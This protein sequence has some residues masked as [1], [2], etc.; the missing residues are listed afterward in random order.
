MQ[1]NENIL[2]VQVYIQGDLASL[3]EERKSASISAFAMVIGVSPDAIEVYRVY[4]G[5]VVFDLGV[6]AAAFQQ[7][8]S[9]LAHNNNQLRMLKVEKVILQRDTNEVEEWI[10]EAGQFQLASGAGSDFGDSFYGKLGGSNITTREAALDEDLVGKLTADVRDIFTVVS[11]EAPHPAPR[12]TVLFLGDLMMRDTEAAYDLIA[13]RW[14][15]H[16]YTPL[17]RRHQTQ[18]A[19]VAQPGVVVPKPSN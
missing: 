8:R 5:S 2:S 4:E 11:V 7:L 3:S 17:L 9:L 6:P 13:E 1:G 19:L 12:G 16:G 15:A 14:Q 18:V 10:N